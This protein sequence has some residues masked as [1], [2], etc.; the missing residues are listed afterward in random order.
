[1][2]GR[3][4]SPPIASPRSW[5]SP[6]PPPRSSRPLSSATKAIAALGCAPHSGWA[7]VIGVGEV[8]GQVRVLVRERVA[9]SPPADPQSKQPYHTVEGL[10]IGEAAPRL[11][12]YA[13]AAARMAGTA[14]EAIV[15]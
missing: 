12:A 13:A 6:I 14:L 8:D 15:E 4:G 7:A 1:M 11:D 3:A 2:R 9:M 5:P 10:P